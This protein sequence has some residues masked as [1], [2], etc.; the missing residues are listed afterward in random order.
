MNNQQIDK[1][2]ARQD[3]ERENQKK[4]I[5]RYEDL[6]KLINFVKYIE[7]DSF[8]RAEIVQIVASTM[9][10]GELKIDLIPRSGSHRIRFGTVD[11]IESKL[12]RLSAFYRNGLTNIGWDMYRTISVEYKGQV[13]CTK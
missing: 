4:L 1:I 12:D 5:K 8:W 13:V 7:E 10:N 9:S 6:L 3:A 11:D 2:T